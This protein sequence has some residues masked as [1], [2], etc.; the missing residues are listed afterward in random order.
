MLKSA[1]SS[2]VY[3]MFRGSHMF[4]E[5]GCRVTVHQAIA[6][7]ITPSPFYTSRELAKQHARELGRQDE[8]GVR[9][10]VREVTI[11]MVPGDTVKW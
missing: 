5:K 2:R 11:S 10:K 8:D 1:R 6:G 4:N 7:T 9:P 3:A